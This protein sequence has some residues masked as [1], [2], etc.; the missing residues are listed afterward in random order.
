MLGGRVS[1]AVDP[2]SRHLILKSFGKFWGLAGL[3]LGFAIGA[4]DLIA[5]LAARLGPWAVSGPALAIGRVALRD[6]AWAQDTRARL[7]KDAA[8]LDGV[9]AR[10]GADIVGGTPLFRLYDVEDAQ[11]FQGRLARHRI[12]SRIFPYSHRWVRLGLPPEDEWARI[13]AAIDT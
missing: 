9:V 2:R 12:W 4:P 8:R 10:A 3:R 13:E 5:R 6:T 1:P 11:A 7:V